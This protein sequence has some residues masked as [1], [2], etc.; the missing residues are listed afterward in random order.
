MSTYTVIAVI[1]AAITPVVAYLIAARQFSGKIETSNA[2]DLWN[3]SRNIR[4]WAMQRIQSLEG[5]V[6]TLEVRVKE[7]EEHN[8]SLARENRQLERELTRCQETR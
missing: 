6:N 7:L 4:D 8:G 3:E 5:A 2:A 1:T